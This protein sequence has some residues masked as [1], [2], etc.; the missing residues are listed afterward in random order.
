LNPMI[1]VINL[2]SLLFGGAILSVR[3][4]YLVTLPYISFKIPI[5]SVILSLILA[6]AIGLAIMF[7]KREPL[8][9]PLEDD[10]T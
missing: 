5:V 8:E 4:S 6:I 3:N 10:T 9:N 2:I 1:K 7:S